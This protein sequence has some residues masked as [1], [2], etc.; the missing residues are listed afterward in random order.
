MAATPWL[1]KSS[2]SASM[3]AS[4]SLLRAPLGR[5]G[6]P[7][8]K[9]CGAP[10]STNRSRPVVSGSAIQHPCNC[11]DADKADCPDHCN[12]CTGLPDVAVISERCVDL[13]VSLK[14]HQSPYP[15]EAMQRPRSNPSL[16][17]SICS[18]RSQRT[19]TRFFTAVRTGLGI[20]GRLY[21]APMT[22]RHRSIV[23][24]PTLKRL[25]SFRL[26]SM[27]AY[28]ANSGGT[29]SD[30]L[31]IMP[32]P[33]AWLLPAVRRSDRSTCARSGSSRS[34]GAMR[35]LGLWS[36]CGRGRIG[37]RRFCMKPTARCR[38]QRA[39]L[40]NVPRGT[41]DAPAPR[42]CVVAT[43]PAIVPAHSLFPAIGARRIRKT[44]TRLLRRSP[45]LSAAPSPL[46]LLIATCISWMR[47]QSQHCIR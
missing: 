6:L 24:P 22:C 26:P 15:P 31:G 14:H 25:R 8:P 4:P 7:G 32:C 34:R 30:G 39:E 17:S 21:L 3:N 20:V 46:S 47:P 5:P 11:S 42:R 23:A 1:L 19:R 43:A 10:A 27:L 35:C 16:R 12:R 38:A 2:C 41:A 37:A 13:P 33:P 40:A 45:S 18:C 44:T 29:G 9:R 28:F 36:S